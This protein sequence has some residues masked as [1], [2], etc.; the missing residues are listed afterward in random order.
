MLIIKPQVHIISREITTPEG[1]LVRAFFAVINIGGAIEIKFLGTKP[2]E[3]TIK[4]R[5]EVLL[6]ENVR[7]QVF[8]DIKEPR[9]YGVVSPYIT[10]D[11]LVSQPTRAPNR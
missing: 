7:T 5:E 9:F 2:I 3:A 10:L 6:L 4:A 8:G 11:F 1:V